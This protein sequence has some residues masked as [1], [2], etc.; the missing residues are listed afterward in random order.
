MQTALSQV[1]QS[2]ADSLV[3]GMVMD[4]QAADLGLRVTPAAVDAELAK[5]MNIPERRE[6]VADHGHAQAGEGRQASA[7]PTDAAWAEAKKRIDDLKAQVDAG[8]DFANA[9]RR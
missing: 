2:G 1:R 4:R 6:L 7:K 8:G 9:G 3:T 5:R